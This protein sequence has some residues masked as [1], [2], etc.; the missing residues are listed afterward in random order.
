MGPKRI[1]SI[2]EYIASFPVDVQE[3]LNSLRKTIKTAAPDAKE[4]ISYQMPAFELYGIL[5]YFAG[6]KKHV[7]FYPTASGIEAFKS[8]LKNYKQGKGSVQFPLDKPIPFDLVTQIVKFKV[9]EN[10]QKH[11][12]RSTKRPIQE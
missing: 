7:G 4:K 2:D 9:A 1:N 6:F 10:I 12:S 5:V 3:K 8:E 11:Q